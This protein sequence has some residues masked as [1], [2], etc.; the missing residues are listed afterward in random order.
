MYNV[1]GV[2]VFTL[3]PWVKHTPVWSAQWLGHKVEA[4]RGWALGYI[5]GV[6]FVLPG[7]VFGGEALFGEPEPDISAVEHQAGEIRE[8]ERAVEDSDLG[9]E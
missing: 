4:N 8:L 7:A 9:I 6:F 1:L 5:T 3:V 2:L